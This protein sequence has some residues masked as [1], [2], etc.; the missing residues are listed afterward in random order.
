MPTLLFRLSIFGDYR[1]FAPTSENTVALT[2][3]LQNAGYALLPNIIQLP[4]QQGQAGEKRMQFVSDDNVIRAVILPERIDVEFTRG[5]SDRIDRLF[6]DTP[7]MVSDILQVVLSALGDPAGRRLAY[8]ADALIPEPDD[9][10]FEPFYQANNLGISL[11]NSPD[12]CTEWNHRFNRRVFLP[13]SGNPELSNAIFSFESGTLQAV[14]AATG[15]RR[16]SRGLRILTDIN[17]L[18]ENAD[19][20]FDRTDIDSFFVAAHAM[21][22]DVLQQLREKLPV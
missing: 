15:Q 12:V 11:H 19:P 7:A 13:V 6:A 20:R 18:H 2:Q 1:Q 14:N 5:A 22:L 21:H 9:G 4:P 16:T 17:T 8:Y 3:S 10:P